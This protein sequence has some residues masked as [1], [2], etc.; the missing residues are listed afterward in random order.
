MNSILDLYLTNSSGKECRIPAGTWRWWILA[1]LI[2]G[3]G[4]AAIWIVTVV[5]ALVCGY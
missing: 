5:L 1:A 4:A 2:G 3:A